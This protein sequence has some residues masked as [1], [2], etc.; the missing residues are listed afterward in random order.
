MSS[1]IKF[2]YR[3]I[4]DKVSEGGNI[5]RMV[6]V[7]FTRISRDIVRVT[8]MKRGKR[9]KKDIPVGELTGTDA[10]VE[11]LFATRDDLCVE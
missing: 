10:L 1:G 11:A 4:F 2:D 9:I 5:D 8:V 7:G 3:V 6:V